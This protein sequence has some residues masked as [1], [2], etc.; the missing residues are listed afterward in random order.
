M[1]RFWLLGLVLLVLPAMAEGAT[2]RLGSITTLDPMGWGEAV[3][4]ELAWGD[5]WLSATAE[6]SQGEGFRAAALGLGYSTYSFSLTNELTF[7]GEGFDSWH[8]EGDFLLG[9]GFSFLVA[10]DFDAG[11]LVGAN[12][13]LSFQPGAGYQEFGL[14]GAVELGEDGGVVGQ[15]IGLR[16]AV[17]PVSLE[18]AA[19]FDDTGFASLD[20]G[21]GLFFE[22]LALNGRA[23]FAPEGFSCAEAGAELRSANLSLTAW[24]LF[25]SDG[26]YEGE[27]GAALYLETVTL[28]GSARFTPEGVSGYSAGLSVSG[29]ALEFGATGDFDSEG[30]VQATMDVGLTLD[31]FEVSL[32]FAWDDTG[33]QSLRLEVWLPF[34][35]GAPA[36]Q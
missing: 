36:G 34:A 7:T 27:L 4:L 13:A 14:L 30:L 25:S 2:G 1:R 35:L 23:S 3:V 24:C 12:L 26:F 22:V 6:F 33:F 5:Y 11:G 17:D 16:A 31:P 19:W 8:M 28:N 29:E 18:T 10:A 9:E 20:V 32:G 21:G 15:E